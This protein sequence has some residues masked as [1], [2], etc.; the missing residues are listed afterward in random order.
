MGGKISAAIA[1]CSSLAGAISEI[2]W[3]NQLSGLKAVFQV[4]NGAIYG[5]ENYKIPLLNCAAS[6]APNYYYSCFAV[7]SDLEC[8]EYERND[9]EYSCNAFL[10]MI[11]HGLILSMV[12]CFLCMLL[13]IAY[14]VVIC[15][16]ASNE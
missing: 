3:F 14:F 11:S 15:K 8:Y 10:T 9:D 2:V 5:N 4:S 13:S 16:N 1:I 6:H 12:L 7:D